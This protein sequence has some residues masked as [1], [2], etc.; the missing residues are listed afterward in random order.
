MSPDINSPRTQS[1]NVTV[2][3]QIGANWQAA[4]S[5]LGSYS[6]R[7]WD[8]VPINPA[9]F[10]GLDPCT[11]NGVF[12]PVCSTTTN[13]NQRRML[14]LE[15]PKEGQLISNIDLFDD[16]NTST[17]RGL[18]LSLERRG[19]SGVSLNGNYTWSYCFGVE[20]TP[21]QNQIGQGPTNPAD[22]AIERGNC[23][24][25]RT[26]IA[27]VTVGY[28]T[29]QFT[30][31]VLRVLASDWRASGII[32][33]SS[34]GWLNVTTGRDN[35]LNGQ[36]STKQRVNQ[37]S[38]DVYGPKT[39]TQYLN[40]AAFVQPAFGTYGNF[41]RNSIRGPGLWFV[42]L[43]LSRVAALAGRQNVEL[44][45]EAFN[46]L[47]HFNW[48]NPV[49]NFGAGNFGRITLQAIDSAGPRIMQFGVKYGF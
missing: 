35:A 4:V 3:R 6:D 41:V 10:M 16:I 40:P 49:T 36:Q 7:L 44:R 13:T 37:V 47:N 15:N 42:N 11:I 28:Q 24:F 23:S 14:Y 45:V 19:T 48:G 43:A 1:W 38:D 2:E 31:S 20:M 22:P 29:P 8:L 39:L 27:N 30:R 21:N 12:Y 33:A 32:S 5:Y 25:N 34:G 18:K 9:K 26:H 17:Y 46:L